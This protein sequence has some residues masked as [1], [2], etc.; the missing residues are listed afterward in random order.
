MEVYKMKVDYSKFFAKL[1]S[2]NIKQ[3]DFRD[4]AKISGVTMQK[5]LHNESVTIDS[6]CKVCDYFRC[7]PNE[8]MEFIPEE[9]YPEDI[10]AKQ[11][12]KQAIE[13]QIA[14]L[15]EKLKNM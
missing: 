14:E 3:K 15:Q 8:I 12:A 9:N 11:Q 4:K 10:K 2:E 6:I 1:K 7:M 13:A 5:M